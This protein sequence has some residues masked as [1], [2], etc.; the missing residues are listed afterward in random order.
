MSDKVQACP[1][2]GKS[3]VAQRNDGS[4]H[5]VMC[6]GVWGEPAVAPSHTDSAKRHSGEM[7]EQDR[8]TAANQLAD[9]QPMIV[10]IRYVVLA[11][12]LS[13]WAVFGF[14]IWIPLL[15]RSILML[16]VSIAS[17]ALTRKSTH[18]AELRLHHAVSFYN[19]G[20]KRVFTAILAPLTATGHGQDVRFFGENAQGGI[21][22]PSLTALL[23]ELGLGT[24]IW[25]CLLSVVWVPLLVAMTRH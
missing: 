22:S 11:I 16:S 13:L 2:C 25:V 23:K 24:V 7:T 1:E 4:W 6:G 12:S 17:A 15:I 18:T 3:D 20:F 19:E 8:A 10:G 9:V 5:C 14:Y 21:V